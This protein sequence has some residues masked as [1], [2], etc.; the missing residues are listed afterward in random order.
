M[1]CPAIILNV[2][3]KLVFNYVGFISKFSPSSA[4]C[5]R[6]CRL[7]Q[8]KIL[9]SSLAKNQVF[10]HVRYKFSTLSTRSIRFA[11]EIMLNYNEYRK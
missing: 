2:I 3:E 6:Q 7:L 11:N 8:A 4:P 10:N 1:T 9:S 5:Q